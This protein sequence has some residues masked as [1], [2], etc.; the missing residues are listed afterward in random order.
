[1]NKQFLSIKELSERYGISKASAYN[2]VRD[3]KLPRGIHI[4][5][6][7]RWALSELEAFER[8]LLEKQEL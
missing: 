5:K 7:H 3:G 1:M 4:G 2:Y 6:A 8:A